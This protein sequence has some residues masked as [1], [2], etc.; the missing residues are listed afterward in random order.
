MSAKQLSLAD[1]APPSDQ[2]QAIAERTGEQ[3]EKDA[4]VAV[5]YCSDHMHLYDPDVDGRPQVRDSRQ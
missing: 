4:L 5:P 3:C 1:F 2:C